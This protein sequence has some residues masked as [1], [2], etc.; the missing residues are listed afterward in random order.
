M[1]FKSDEGFTL[2]ELL[3][4]LSLMSMVMIALYSSLDYSVRA[5][6]RTVRFSEASEDVMQIQHL[7]RDT[8]AQSFPR[9]GS[10]EGTPSYMT[11]VTSLSKDGQNSLL[12]EVTLELKNSDLVMSWKSISDLNDEGSLVLVDGFSQAHFEYSGSDLRRVGNWLPV[13]TW[14]THPA[15]VKIALDQ[16]GFWPEMVIETAL[17]HTNDCQYDPVTRECRLR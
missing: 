6:E 10:F 4:S 7:I 12:Y 16:D 17:T 2:I 13:W 1:N 15:F 9:S 8:I 3:V 11:F 5:V 14:E